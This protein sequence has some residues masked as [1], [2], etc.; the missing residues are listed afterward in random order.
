MSTG[1]MVVV[2]KGGALTALISGLFA[3]VIALILCGTGLGWYGLNLVDR[4]SSEIVGMGRDILAAVPDVR[5]SLPVLAEGLDDR[6]APD[7]RDQLETSVTVR[8]P[9][10]HSTAL[11]LIE[12]ENKGPETVT[13]LTGR[14]VLTDDNGV[15]YE[16]SLYIA[17][18]FTI[19]DDWR[20]PLLPGS[21]RRIAV[22]MRTDGSP[23]TN[24]TLEITDLRLWNRSANKNPPADAHAELTQTESAAARTE[25]LQS[26]AVESAGV[27]SAKTESAETE[28]AG[29]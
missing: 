22:R 27:E 26:P 1:P 6:R 18:P 19:D 29:D 24:G 8:T 14:V 9:N 25:R 3:T 21:T 2:K 4:K 23:A 28:S 17:T 20:G 12:V 10:R 7:Y 15:P 16:R 5:Q 13:L 11:A